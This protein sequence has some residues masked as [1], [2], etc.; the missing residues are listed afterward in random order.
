[1]I[2][3]SPLLE[4]TSVAQVSGALSIAQHCLYNLELCVF[5]QILIR[6]QSYSY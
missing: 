5:F 4:A 2:D 1:M 6:V 3:L